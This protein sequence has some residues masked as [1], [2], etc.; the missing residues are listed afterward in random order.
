MIVEVVHVTGKKCLSEWLDFIQSFRRLYVVAKL[1]IL[2]KDIIVISQNKM[3]CTKAYV[4]DF[5]SYSDSCKIF[6]N[7]LHHC[8]YNYFNHPDI[9]VSKEQLIHALSLIRNE[10]INKNV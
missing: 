7:D 8:L 3:R 2:P 10:E 9:P 5:L 4:V 6:D 1:A